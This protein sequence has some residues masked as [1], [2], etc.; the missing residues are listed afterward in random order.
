MF[1]G[2]TGDEKDVKHILGKAERMGRVGIKSQA[3]NG[4]RPP[5]YLGHPVLRIVSLWPIKV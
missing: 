3:Q 4:R 2:H 1:Q 5:V